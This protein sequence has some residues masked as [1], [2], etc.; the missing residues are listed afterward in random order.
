MA[1][2]LL[3]NQADIH[4]PNILG[5]TCL[6]T[7]V[8][9][10][11]KLIELLINNG[12]EINA[13]DKYNRT[14]LHHAIQLSEAWRFRSSKILLDHGADPFVKSD[15]DGDA[16]E[17][18]SNV[19]SKEIFD[20]LISKFNFCPQHIKTCTEQLKKKMMEKDKEDNEESTVMNSISKFFKYIFH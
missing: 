2:F 11:P 13:K 5:V 8:K 7:S 6:M 18:A 1:E 3:E 19:P 14:A 15:E 9:S 4:K 16:L 12:A 17:A 20:Y 10:S